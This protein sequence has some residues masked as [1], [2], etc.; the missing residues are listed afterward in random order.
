MM[1][2]TILILPAAFILDKPWT[3]S[4]DLPA[5]LSVLALAV[6]GTSL[7]YILYFYLLANVGA[8][9][10][11][12]ITFII[13]LS[14]VGLGMLFLGERPGINALLGLILIMSGVWG[15][16][17]G[18]P[19]PSSAG[20]FDPV[21]WVSGY[22]PVR[23]QERLINFTMAAVCLLFLGRRVMEYGHFMLKPLW[24]VETLIFLVL[25]GAYLFRHEA[26]DRSR[27]VTEI[28]V[29]LA[30]ALLPFVLLGSPPAASFSSDRNAMLV[31]FW[32]MTAATALTVWGMW[33]LKRS[34]SITVEARS[35]VTSGAYRFLRH[36]VYAGEI[37]TAAVVMA[38][39]FSWVNLAVLAAFVAI[40]LYRAR[41]EE[42]KLAENFF[43]YDEFR[44][45]SWWVWP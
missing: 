32:L 21:G 10:T 42:R 2:G 11:S 28:M 16:T 7:A 43:E 14:G 39:R 17:G 41:M 4:P 5:L 23:T 8:T 15:V 34:F 13:P 27:G 6:L 31:I 3:L 20:A 9:N 33:S 38:W 1:G 12:L 40:Q 19:L 22:V 36:P 30:G 37:L 26:T 18:V 35:L 25:I 29:P 24:A 45:K 44:R